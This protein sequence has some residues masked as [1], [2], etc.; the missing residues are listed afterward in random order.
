MLTIV[1]DNTAKQK[2]SVYF[3]KATQTIKR[4]FFSSLRII[5]LYLEVII[6]IFFLIKILVIYIVFYILIKNTK[7]KQN[8][9]NTITKKNIFYNSILTAFIEIKV[10]S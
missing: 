9:K 8:N 3:T 5:K 10:C 4:I 6:K 7:T 2:K 1:L